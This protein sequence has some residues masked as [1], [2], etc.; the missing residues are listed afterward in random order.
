MLNKLLKV[1]FLVVV[2]VLFTFINGLVLIFLG[3]LKSLHAYSMIF[4]NKEGDKHVAIEILESVD[5][6]L[7]ALV[8][9]I[10]SL[11]LTKLFLGNVIEEDVDDKLPKWL[12][13]K[14]FLEL[15]MLLW[16]T[17]LVSLVVLFVDV[18]FQNLQNI[19]WNLLI[20]PISI[21]ILSISI[22][23]VNKLEK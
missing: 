13:I 19:D 23:L 16:Q 15:K 11:G 22:Y 1:R 4:F 14:N 10:F 2:I 20:L 12:K 7:V 6:F 18:I 3:A 8:F 9:I 21:L 5:L 17:I